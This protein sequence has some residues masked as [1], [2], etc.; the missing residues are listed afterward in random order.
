[1]REY[2]YDRSTED[3]RLQSGSRYSRVAYIE[4]NQRKGQ[5][6]CRSLD[7]GCMS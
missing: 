2:K 6:I 4:I 5:Q 7:R 1:M 3:V